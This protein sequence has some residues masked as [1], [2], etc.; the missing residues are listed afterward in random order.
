MVTLQTFA[1]GHVCGGAIIDPRW[2]LTA[3]HCTQTTPDALFVR[4]GGLD[5]F[6]S[7]TLHAI[8]QIINHPQFSESN[9]ANDISLV[10]TTVTISFTPN[11]QPIAIGSTF[12]FGG[13]QA[14][15]KGWGLIEIGERSDFLHWIPTQTITNSD[16]RFRWSGGAL[17]PDWEV[18]DA[19]ICTLNGAAQGFCS[20]DSGGP[21]SSG[22][23][24]IG[25]LSWGPIPCGQ[26]MPSVHERVSSHR[27]WILET[28]A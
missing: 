20:T 4:V 27:E 22:D 18:S 26:E 19:K 17:M 16:C 3:A 23:S 5:R 7:G 15:G 13:V 6:E 1:N 10:Q 28:I 9:T 8:S 14:I 25:V 12:V 2:I 21:L 11:V 24:L